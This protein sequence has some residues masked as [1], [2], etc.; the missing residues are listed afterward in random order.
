[1]PLLY[2]VWPLWA[3]LVWGTGFVQPR[4]GIT[5]GKDKPQTEQPVAAACNCTIT[6]SGNSYPIS[7][8]MGNLSAPAFYS[9][10]VPNV[11]S[12]NT[13]LELSN[14]LIL[15]LY[16][17]I[18]TGIIS[19][20]LIADVANSGTGGSM[21]FETSCLPATAYVS[22]QDDAGEF[23]GVP[24]S[25]TG[26]WS[27]VGCC[28]DGGAITDLGCNNT[29]N[30]DLLV[31]NGIDSIVWLTGDIL[32]PTHILLSAGGEVITINCGG[33]VCC[34]LDFDTDIQVQDATC[35]DSPNGG[36]DLTPQDGIPPFTYNWSNGA[37]T[38]DISDLLPG[39]Y[40]V[41]ITDSQGCSEELNMTVDVS[42]GAPLAAPAEMELCSEDPEAVFD[43]TSVEEVVNLNTGL[44]VLWFLNAD[45]TGAISNPSTFLSSSTT[46]YAVV[47][48]GFCL[49]EPVPVNLMVLP[50]PVGNP[51]SMSLCEETNGMATFD[52][53]TLDNSVSSGVGMVVWYEDSGLSNSISSPDNF[54]SGSTIV[55]AVVSD[56]ACNSSPVEV[57]LTVDLK[58]LGN[59]ASI[60]L[61]GDE[62][63]EAVFDLTSVESEISGGNFAISWYEDVD[64][65]QPIV[66]V[67][68]YVSTS[69][70]VYAV[71]FDGICYSDPIPVTL[72]VEPTP[73]GN[74]ITIEACDDGSGEAVFDLFSFESQI[75]GGTSGVDW[76]LDIFLNEPIPDPQV[77]Q[78]ESTIVYAVIDNGLCFSDPVPITLN[79][80]LTPVGNPETLETCAD[81]TGQGVFNLTSIDNVVSGGVGTVS[82]YEDVFGNDLISTPS[83]F[84]TTG[85]IVYAKITDGPCVSALVPVELIIINSVTAIPS[86][87]EACDAGGDIG[88]FNL[89]TIE[90]SISGG[91]G[92][93]SWYLDSLGTILLPSPD[94]F[95][96]GD[97]IVYA[98]VTAG[99]CVSNLVPVVLT[100]LPTPQSSDLVLD[101]CGNAIGETSIDL[102]AYDTL[103]SGNVGTVSWYADSSLSQMIPLPSAFTSGDTVIYAVVST[104][105]CTSA[106]AT[107]AIAVKPALT[108][109]SQ[110]I[111]LCVPMGDSVILN[112]TAYDDTISG[113]TYQVNWYSDSMA[114][115]LLP[116]PAAAVVD[117]SVILYVNITDGSCVSENVPFQIEVL[118][119]PV[120]N[121]ISILKCGDINGQAVFDLAVAEV[122]VSENTGILTWYA[123]TGG[124][125]PLMNP[126]AFLSG[127]TV[128]YAVV[129]NGFCLAPVATVQLDV[130]D[131]L[132]ATPVLLQSC[133][134]D[135]D[136]AILDLTLSD[137]NI[138]GGSG[139]VI[140]YADAL[141][142][143]TIFTPTLFATTGD[144][145]YAQ[146]VADGCESN[147]AAI[148]I[149]VA[150]S[151]FPLP[152]C[153]FTS[154]DSISMS[155]LPVA[156]EYLLS[157]M[158][159]GQ[160]IGISIP[161]SSTSF[162]LGGLGQGDTIVLTVEAIYDSI[163]TNSLTNTVTCI[164][165]V[166][167]AVALSFPGLQS[168]YCRDEPFILVAADPPGGQLT[169][170]GI[171][172]DTLFPGLVAGNASTLL[173]T[174][175]DSATGCAYNYSTV[176][177]IS[178]PLMA[179]V[180]NCL[181][182]DLDA[183]SFNWNAVQ[184]LYGYAYAI[185]EGTLSSPVQVTSSPLVINNLTEGD[186]VR[187]LLWAI[188]PAPCGNS[189]TVS[190]MCHTRVCP[191]A[192]LDILDPVILC[193][194]TVPFQLNVAYGGIIGTPSVTWQGNAVVDPA[195][196]FDPNLAVNGPNLVVVVVEADGCQYSTAENL[197]ITDVPIDTVE[198]VCI[199]EDFNSVVVEWSP[200]SGAEG[201]TF[202]SS[203][204]AGSVDGNRYTI[205]HLPDH[206][207]V[208][209]TVIAFDHLG[210]TPSLATI[211][212][213]TL[214]RIP[215]NVFIPNIFSPNQ[216]GINDIFFIQSNPEVTGINVMRIFDRWGDVVFEKFDF[217][218]NDPVQGWDGSF[219]GKAM[220][221]GVYTY[222]VELETSRGPEI[223]FGDITLTR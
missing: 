120:A 111:E 185:N 195:G 77:F 133:L 18:P 196:T 106:P 216:D 149:E 3:S 44:N 24:P 124:T 26:M 119:I 140:W 220:N 98:R 20:F 218:P 175:E 154:I 60:N 64:L 170:L 113:G 37:S 36:V 123:D 129:A 136:T 187:L 176:V 179:P 76:F 194:D 11:S 189:D 12:A 57:E 32:N 213:Q 117:S 121:E 51:A 78:T 66:N 4:S 5:P 160:P 112:L 47:D 210:C 99:S 19:L 62:N 40:T 151:S 153:D 208:L 159:N 30:L 118:S 137:I 139:S 201:Y 219:D 199:E 162:D 63:D 188:G 178:E 209:I 197:V 147:V 130:T 45:M 169:G 145:L 103:I 96:G 155:W 1:M 54:F 74:S 21:Q 114:T 191:P 132:I 27:W 2:L 122:L 91:S 31:S 101:L 156:D 203:L 158:I 148:V 67:A 125:I 211:E 144:T 173:Y 59:P 206:T 81:S 56:G 28:T 127:D 157:Y 134:L 88:I 61:C 46:V 22:V 89:T 23:N 43:L 180:L 17:E 102:T 215:V 14:A 69:V 161:A 110:L 207:E 214:E 97:A 165:D 212:C 172:G 86:H 92:Q 93:V 146:V 104:S 202:T 192:T 70:I 13:G 100:V 116:F 72:T 177:T 42:P 190:A 105:L 164:T 9:Y 138:S 171:S 181:D 85:T 7:A 167:P 95:P 84:M 107:I 152:A 131:S 71:V 49:S 73:I 142:T 87:A 15:F 68:A 193:S 168:V 200:A 217:Q 65:E 39:L 166:C 25:I 115:Q 79:V 198:L 108:A 184:A 143:D 52:L 53:T 83:V 141:G 6:Q 223:L 82:W 109:V 75:T 126:G 29:I 33:G 174:W 48:N 183:V 10:G 80:L 163:C 35:P 204:G 186:S 50:T 150:S 128:V 90:N 58:P 16:E 222:I 182:Q 41:T 135:Q 55:Y 8:L 94:S 38:E 205:T 221:P 34:P